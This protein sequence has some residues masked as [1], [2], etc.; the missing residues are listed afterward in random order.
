MNTSGTASGML[1]GLGYQ[2]ELGLFKFKGSNN[3]T[4]FIEDNFLALTTSSLSMTGPT[5][6][7]PLRYETVKGKITT[8]EVVVGLNY[9]L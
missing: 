7:A 1:F 2:H 6:Q 3:L 5:D 9:Y 4:W 8:N